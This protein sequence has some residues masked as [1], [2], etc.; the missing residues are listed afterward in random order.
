[1]AGT[2]C[3]KPQRKG[4]VFSEGRPRPQPVLRVLPWAPWGRFYPQSRIAGTDS[5]ASGQ[6]AGEPLPSWRLRFRWLRRKVGTLDSALRGCG[7]PAGSRGLGGRETLCRGSQLSVLLPFR[8]TPREFTQNPPG[9][10]TPF[11]LL[12]WPGGE[13]GPA[14]WL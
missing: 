3:L 1:M 5:D 12:P 9:G 11:S 14:S 2:L 6:R 13:A 8:V 7:W 4:T 10:P